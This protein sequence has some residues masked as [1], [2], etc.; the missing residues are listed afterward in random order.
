[1]RPRRDE[2]GLTPRQRAV[3]NLMVAGLTP[4]EV[5]TRLG[6]TLY[7]VYTYVKRIQAALGVHSQ[8][9]LVAKIDGR[10]ET[11]PPPAGY[12]AE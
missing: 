6:V 10:L 8:L 1:M 9:A 4:P 2:H 12:G 3:A 11:L 5:A 7:T